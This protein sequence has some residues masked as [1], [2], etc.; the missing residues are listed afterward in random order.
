MELVLVCTASLKDGWGIKLESSGII[1]CCWLI[2]TEIGGVSVTIAWVAT[3]STEIFL[4]SSFSAFRFIESLSG[5]SAYWW[6][7]CFPSFSV[8]S[9]VHASFTS[10]NSNVS[11]F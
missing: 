8:D 6:S 9:T 1:Y 5:S 7:V 2:S 4:W 10:D 11:L 3:E